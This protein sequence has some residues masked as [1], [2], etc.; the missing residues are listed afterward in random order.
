[1][2]I[3]SVP[4][5]LHNLEPSKQ[6]L[7]F[8][9]EKVK[10]FEAQQDQLIQHLD[11]NFSKLSKER[12]LEQLLSDKD[13]KLKLL[14]KTSSDLTN[15]LHNQREYGLQLRAENDR[16]QIMI[17]ED[18][19]K[20]LL[21]KALSGIKDE[22]LET[23]LI[24]PPDSLPQPP[25][26]LIARLKGMRMKFPKQYPNV[27][28]DPATASLQIGSL[29]SQIEEKVKLSTEREET[30]RAEVNIINEEKSTLIKEYQCT[31]DRLQHEL[32]RTQSLLYEASKESL[33]QVGLVRST[34]QHWISEKDQ[35][36]SQLQ[37]VHQHLG[38]TDIHIDTDV[39]PI[40]TT[41]I[42]TNSRRQ[43]AQ[44]QKLQKDLTAAEQK[45]SEE[46]NEKAKLEQ[47]V[48]HLQRQCDAQ[49]SLFKDRV[50]KLTSQLTTVK[51]HYTELDRRRKLHVEGYRS[52]IQLVRSKI[53]DVEKLLYKV[54]VEESTDLSSIN[55]D[56]Q[57]LQRINSN[58]KAAK[59]LQ[60][61]IHEAKQQIY[62]V[63]N[64]LK[65]L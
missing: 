42:T 50:G 52:D 18:D 14:Q 6:L 19:R 20:I 32:K 13:E 36:L 34:Q 38:L 45:R 25:N 27:F 28:C 48:S 12:E 9:R 63:E 29:Q 7:E 49:K 10:K 65:K 15:Q 31:I 17:L 2:D 21:L 59:Q 57:V 58:V 62:T 41:N 8:Y 24:D 11:R 51:S 37:D 39:A 30:L 26:S 5:R 61:Q 35:L 55:M 53:R 64:Q 40:R 60:H 1:M 43:D 46:K 16:L 44:I 23:L 56:L 22:E 3:P 54:T 4:V 33:H 47:E